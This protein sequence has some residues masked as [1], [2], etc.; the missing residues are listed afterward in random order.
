MQDVYICGAAL[1]FIL[2]DVVS[3]FIAALK[4]NEVSSSIMREGLFKKAGSLMLL[5]AAVAVEHIGVYAGIDESITTAIMLSVG[6]LIVVMELTSVLENICK[7]NPDIPIAKAFDLFGLNTTT[8]TA[9]NC[10]V[11]GATNFIC[12]YLS[13]VD[14]TDDTKG[15]DDI[16]LQD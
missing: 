7:I 14:A 3:G 16:E 1:A 5:V 15:D 10:V 8:A 4:N 11:D 13:G 9:A 12:P 6:G 2:L